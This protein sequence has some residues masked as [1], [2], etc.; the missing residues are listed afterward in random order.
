MMRRYG[1]S[2][3]TAASTAA[4]VAMLGLVAGHAA[5]VDFEGGTE[6]TEKAE[7]AERARAGFA[8]PP[9]LRRLVGV[10]HHLHGAHRHDQ[11][12]IRP[13]LEHLP[14]TPAREPHSIAHLHGV[15]PLRRLRP[16]RLLRPLELLPLLP[17]PLL[18]QAP[19]LAGRVVGRA[20]SGAECVLDPLARVEQVGARLLAAGALRLLLAALEL[21]LTRG[22]RLLLRREPGAERVE[23]DLAL[24]E[25]RPR[26]GQLALPLLD[27]RE[28][29]VE[30]PLGVGHPG[31][32]VGQDRLRDAQTAR[33]RQPVRAAGHAL[34][35]TIGRRERR[36]VELERGVHH[37]RR[38]AGHVLERAQVR[39]GERE[40]AARR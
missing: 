31:L 32:G 33:D 7:T 13:N 39:G 4:T 14:G 27:R 28:Q 25:R 18:H 40:R 6:R 21:R 2:A 29:G 12:A 16:L 19:R 1:C 5:E 37:A 22:L 36:R 38:V 34:Q 23:L 11:L 35:E 17:D 10:H 24:G 9:L 3:S 30:T 20:P 15:R 8:D 26:Q